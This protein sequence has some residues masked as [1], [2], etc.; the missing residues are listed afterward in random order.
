MD[1]LTLDTISALVIQDKFTREEA[2][3]VTERTPSDSMLELWATA[4][5]E[6]THPFCLQL[7]PCQ[8]HKRSLLA[9]EIEEN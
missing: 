5:S 2:T 1:G 4:S 3:V 6:I 7:P 8:I 9:A